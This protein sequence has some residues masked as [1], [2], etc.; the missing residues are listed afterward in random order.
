MLTHNRETHVFRSSIH[1]VKEKPGERGRVTKGT[2]T[3]KGAE[4]RRDG[5]NSKRQRKREFIQ[6]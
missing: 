5:E 1:R 3:C 4:T 6:R 2:R